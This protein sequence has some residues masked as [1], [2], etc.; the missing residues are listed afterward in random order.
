MRMTATIS[1][2][3]GWA[4]H[5]RERGLTLAAI[6]LAT[7]RMAMEQL[8]GRAAGHDLTVLLDGLHVDRLPLLD[9]AVGALAVAGSLA[10]TCTTGPV[11]TVVVLLLPVGGPVWAGLVPMSTTYKGLRRSWRLLL[12][13]AAG[14]QVMV[15]PM[16]AG[17]A[18]LAPVRAASAAGAATRTIV[19]PMQ[20]E[21]WVEPRVSGHT[22]DRLRRRAARRPRPAARARLDRGAA[23]GR[24]QP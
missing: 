3:V 21:A 12:R 10:E 17:A 19:G 1:G 2:W 18:S 15:L 23:P 16:L 11:G 5:L 4:S 22:G 24:P 7:V 20:L 13:V 9:G 8:A 14:A 6:G